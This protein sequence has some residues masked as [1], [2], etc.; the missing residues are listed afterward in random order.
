MK[1]E[2]ETIKQK[3]EKYNKEFFALWTR[4]ELVDECIRLN[5]VIIDCLEI[6]DKTK[7]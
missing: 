6:I 7:L 4:E 3:R 2:K 5:N 1:K